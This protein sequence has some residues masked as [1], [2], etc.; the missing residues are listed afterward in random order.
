MLGGLAPTPF[1]RPDA[2]VTVPTA[3]SAFPW[4]YDRRSTP[5]P[6]ATAEARNAADARYNVVHFVTMEH[7][8]HFPAFEQP[9]AWMKDLLSVARPE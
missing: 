1:P 3:C 8:G 7:G 2:R 4:Q 9:Q 6:P 5:P